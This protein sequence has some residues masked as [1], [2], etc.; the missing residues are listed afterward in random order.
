MVPAMG[1]LKLAETA[2]ATAQPNRSRPVMPLA[3]MR[4][5]TQLD[6]TAAI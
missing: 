2:A 5:D 6:M 4:S 3:W 1:A